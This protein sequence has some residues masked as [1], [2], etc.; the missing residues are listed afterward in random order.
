MF[1]HLIDGKIPQNNENCSNSN[2]F[3][4][5]PYPARK[6]QMSKVR[7]TQ[8]WFSFHLFG[9]H[10]TFTSQLFIAP[11]R[12]AYKLSVNAGRHARKPNYVE[13]DYLILVTRALDRP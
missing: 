4:L 3:A 9:K 12:L 1:G 2:N 8:F 5:F 6:D 7:L 10:N 13:C 11:L